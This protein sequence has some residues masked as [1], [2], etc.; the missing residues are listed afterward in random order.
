MINN[1]K[2]KKWKLIVLVALFLILLTG[3]RIVWIALFHNTDQPS[4]R[5][6]QLDLRDW[7]ASEGGVIT[8]DGQ[9]KFYSH[10]WLIDQNNEQELLPQMLEVPGSWN[11]Y[12]QPEE[13]TPYGYGSYR[14]QILIDPAD[15][16]TYSIR[17]PSIRSSSALY[18]NDRLLA[19]SGQP[20]ENEEEY[21]A[22]NVPY[23]ASFST[24]GHNVIEVVIQVANYKDS[25]ASGIIRSLKFGTEDAIYRE[26]QLSMTMQQMVA[27]VFLMHAV[28]ALIL[29]FMGDRKKKL[30]YFSLLAVGL[31]LNNLI[32]SEEKILHYWFPINYEWGFKLAHLAIIVVTYSLLQCVTDQIPARW[33]KVIPMYSVLYVVAVLLTILLPVRNILMLQH[34][35]LLLNASTILIAIVLLLRTSSNEFKGSVLFA[36]SLIAVTSNMLWAVFYQATGIK[37]LYY[38]L[39]LIIAT[40]CFASVWFR[41][42]VQV[43]VET[44][45]LAAKLLRADKQKDLFLANTSHELRN[46]LHGILNISQVVLER[47]QHSLH[48][49]SVKDLETILS[50]GRRMSLMLNDL[51]DSMSLK[52]GAVRL[53][54]SS[55]SI[56]AIAIGVLDMLHLMREGKPVRF[57]NQIPE[58][59]PQVFAD[60]HRVIQIL[61][62]L[63]HNALK[64]TNE[65]KVSI[66]AEVKDGRAYITISDTGIGMD[67]ETVRRVFEPYEQAISDEAMIEGG[68]GLGLSI[69]K[70]LVELHGGTLQASSVPGQGSEFL[71]SLQLSDQTVMQEVTE[72]ST[73]ESIT[74][75]ESAVACAL[76][77][78]I[79]TQPTK[80]SI[81]RPRILVVDD[82][83]VNLK[84]LE[85]ILSLE[86]YDIM[87]V[88]NGKQ[89]LEVLGAKEWDLVISDVMMPQMSGYELARKIR[90]RFTITE[91]PILLLTARSRSEDIENGFLS[92]ANDYV[93]KPVDAREIRSRVRALTEVKQS[94]RERLRMEA[95]WLQAQIQP[96]FLFNTLNAV[97][98]LSEIDLDQ[99]RNL[100]EVFS[101]FLR[102]K[103]KFKN[104]DE[105]APLEDELSIVRSYL[106]IEQ[107]RFGDRLQVIWEI[108]DCEQLEIPLL[109]IQPLV[110]NAIKHGIMKRVQGG[111]I[112]IRIASFETYAEIVVEDDGVGMDEDILLKSPDRIS[113]TGSGVGLRNTD[114][115]LK[116]HFG[117]GLQIKSKPG[118][119]TSI[120][121]IVYKT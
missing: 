39:D 19:G 31:M 71:F 84:V 46:P 51:L 78:S 26:T 36:F 2:R 104:T 6:G 62:N 60:E 3:G 27:V 99:M 9:W 45:E 65:G 42:Y 64:Y 8:L 57:V 116:R 15:D 69:S 18:V 121:F 48:E 103:F 16:L 89:A 91:L 58:S 13:E 90:E 75:E 28:Y 73:F 49:K 63:L 86:Q 81:D 96:H 7:D 20:G 44:K 37:I 77:D 12:L 76:P 82:D 117:K 112:L 33:R 38:P 21:V 40:T 102:D 88:T 54:F 67:D 95:A 111:K 100:L 34:F 119:G 106:Y 50:V 66:R 118:E 25:R 29:Y 98:A 74:F 68:F 22:K 115:R 52:E 61:F 101:S 53:H 110:E 43:H 4:A 70:Q 59:F 93:T 11:A 105:L 1:Q 114:L 30:L 79:S 80:S 94:V 107:V 109:T 35:Y 56:H 83:P 108:E 24:N 23:T 87:L 55:F 92:G 113:S 5:A 32:A 72:S 47:E 14:L 85:T 17:I 120:S 10:E 97:A 41:N